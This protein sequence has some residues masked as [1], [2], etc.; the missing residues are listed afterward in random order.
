MSS[1]SDSSNPRSGQLNILLTNFRLAERT[2]A[3]SYVRDIAHALCAEHA[4]AVYVSKKGSLAEELEAGGV[5]VIEDPAD[6]PFSPDIIHGQFN[7]ET[8]VALLSFPEIPAIY[9]SHGTQQ[10][11]EE[12]PVHPR[13][14]RYL[15]FSAEV[16]DRMESELGIEEDR[17]EVVPDFIDTD[18]FN[19]IR[20]LPEKPTRALV[21]ERAPAKAGVERIQQA[22]GAC[23]IEVDTLPDLIGKVATRAEVLLP[24]YDLVFASGRSALEAI[25]AGCAVVPFQGS[26]WGEL[27]TSSNYESWRDANFVP[28][29]PETECGAPEEL[30]AEVRTWDWRTLAPVTRRLREEQ[31]VKSTKTILERIYYEVIAE[32]KANGPSSAH[33]ARAVAQWLMRLAEN[34]HAIDSGYLAIQKEANR[35]QLDQSDEEQDELSTK[36][37]SEKEKIRA[38]QRLLMAVNPSARNTDRESQASQERADSASS[39]SSLPG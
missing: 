18:R 6:C 2:V 32:N 25:A 35:Y 15:G 34:H 27:I 20:R 26:L 14:R 38:T 21:Y 24:Q 1:D 39:E 19:E 9:V 4:V 12:P 11:R 33:E 29:A 30:A 31:S 13:I 8:M 3:E 37:L 22:C 5:R 23:G 28:R 10:W 36:L 7:L 16:R 17:I